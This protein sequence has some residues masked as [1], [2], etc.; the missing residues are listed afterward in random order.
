MA[1]SGLEEEHGAGESHPENL[2]PSD[3]AV[4]VFVEELDVLLG[5]AGTGFRTRVLVLPSTA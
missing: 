3:A 2:D 5:I 4:T 1:E